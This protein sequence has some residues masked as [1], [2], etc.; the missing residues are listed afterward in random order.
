MGRLIVERQQQYGWGRSIVESLASDLRTEFV[1]MSG[2]SAQNLWYMRQFYVEYSQSQLLQPLVGEISWSKHLLIL[3]K[4][5]DE[6]ERLF[7][8]IQTKR[9]GW[10]KAVLTNQIENRTY[11]KTVVNQQNFAETLP[12]I[13]LA[14]AVLALKDE[15]AFDFL[16][17]ANEHSE[18]EMEQALLANIRKFLIE[19]GGDFTFIGNQYRLELEGREFFIDLLLYHRELQCLVAIELKIDEFK[20]E[21]AGKMNFYLSVLNDRVRKAHEKPS[22]GIIICKAK[23]RTIVEFA[24]RDVNKPIGVATYSLTPTLPQELSRF[25]PTNEQLIERVEALTDALRTT[26]NNSDPV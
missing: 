25:F 12:A 2:F 4:C 1:G 15:Y 10:T 22:I 26:K 7:Y 13:T 20:P 11:Q 19:M 18:Y 6:N 14:K 8:T 23:E 17:L 16:E 3:S 24:L 21:H 9:H 5:K